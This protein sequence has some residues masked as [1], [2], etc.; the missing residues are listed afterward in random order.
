M[1][2]DVLQTVNGNTWHV[3]S[4]FVSK[5][6]TSHQTCSDPAAAED[7][8]TVQPLTCPFSLACASSPFFSISAFP[9]ICEYPAS[10][11]PTKTLLS[12]KITQNYRHAL[13]LLLLLQPSGRHGDQILFL[14]YLSPYIL[15]IVRKHSTPHI[16]NGKKSLFGGGNPSRPCLLLA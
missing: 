15:R 3:G 12:I 9:P 16:A 5:E 10:Y 6:S 1:A 4:T 11:F 2:R 8:N 14:T 7:P 13:L